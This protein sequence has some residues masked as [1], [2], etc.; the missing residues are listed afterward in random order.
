MPEPRPIKNGCLQGGNPHQYGGRD[1]IRTLIMGTRPEEFEPVAAAYRQTAE[2]LTTTIT[3]LGDSAARLVAD[4]DWGGDSARAMLTR[5]NRLQTYLQ[6]LRDRLQEIPPSLAGVAQELATAKEQ[7]DQATAPRTYYAMGAGSTDPGHPTN[8]PDEAARA[9]ITRL[10]GAFHT[11]HAALPDRLPWDAELA[12]TASSRQP[13]AGD[14]GDRG[15]RGD[16]GD[17]GY[18]GLGENTTPLRLGTELA[19]TAGSPQTAQG[20]VPGTPPPGTPPATGAVPGAVPP[21]AAPGP[22]PAG[23][24]VTATPSGHLGTTYLTGRSD[25]VQPL[26]AGPDGQPGAAENARQPQSAR[27]T[28]VAPPAAVPLTMRT[29]PVA[30]PVAQ[31]IDGPERQ[32]PTGRDTFTAQGPSVRPGSVPVV[33]G[34]PSAGLPAGTGGHGAAGAAGAAGAGGVPFL[35]MAAGAPLDRQGQR[36]PGTQRADDD[37]FR[38]AADTPPPVVG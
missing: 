35:P 33:G 3:T 10:N 31:P 13:A 21:A 26:P 6:A 5:M 1:A 32:I 18:G 11:A 20:T 24:P 27:P 19:G 9:F 7:F 25:L 30:Q 15:D 17:G 22:G 28:A 2:L 4:G 12:R 37:F 23:T 14:G 36:R 29:T 38:P 8:D 34:S 16:R